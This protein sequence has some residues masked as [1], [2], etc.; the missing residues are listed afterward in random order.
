MKPAQT[1]TK[2]TFLRAWR[3]YRGLMQDELAQRLDISTAVL[4]RIERGSQRYNQDFLEAVATV[5]GCSPVDLLS[6]DPNEE[7]EIERLLNDLDAEERQK[8]ISIIK[9]LWGKP[10]PNE[11]EAATPGERL[12]LART[13]AGFPS[14][15]DAARAKNF[16]KQNLAD[17]ESGRRNISPEHAQEY[18]RAFGVS[19]SWLLYGEQT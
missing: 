9:L 4:S 10:N 1:Q 13:A 7:D 14:I 2:P 15:A 5:L 3:K 16:H 17:H 12:R 8:A 18:A 19:A 6:R 11:V